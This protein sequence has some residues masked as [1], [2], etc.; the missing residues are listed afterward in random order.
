MTTCCLLLSE[1][2]E[3]VDI[4]LVDGNTNYADPGVDFSLTC[5]TQSL[6]ETETLTTY[7]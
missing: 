5:S 4:I 3:V 2:S 7:D 6:T 1:S